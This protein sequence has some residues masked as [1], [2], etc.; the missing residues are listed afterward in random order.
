MWI[1]SCVTPMGLLERAVSYKDKVAKGLSA[2][3][4]L[5][6]Y[7][8]LQAADILLYD[9]DVVP[10]GQDQ[11]QHLEMARDIAVKFN[12]AYAPVLKLPEPEISEE[13]AVIPG[14]DGAKMSKSYG[15]TVE[16]FAEEK[17]LRK[18]IMGIVTDSTPLEAP[19]DPAGSTVVALYK[20]FA[21]KD[22]VRR[23]EDE[24]RAGGVGYGEFKKRLFAAMWEYFAP[25]RARREE[26][27]ARPD[28]LEDVLRDGAARAREIAQGT[29]D[30]VRTA[31]GLR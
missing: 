11:K 22:E 9:A 20:L 26:I 30:R 4:G 25:L 16:M 15:N 2:N 31:V 3:A 17:A 12:E 23:M 10:V 27:L 6:T 28:Y 5:F 1:L 13:V 8:V 18:R 14:T 21:G 29:M 7:P 19:K 24:H